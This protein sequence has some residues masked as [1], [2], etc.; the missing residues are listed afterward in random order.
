MPN[1]ASFGVYLIAHFFAKG[2]GGFQQQPGM[3]GSSDSQRS[4]QGGQ[5]MGGGGASAASSAAG[6]FNQSGGAQAQQQSYQQGKF[7]K[8]VTILLKL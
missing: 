5:M 4:Q 8:L 7:V 6:M 3:Q 2:F 1:L